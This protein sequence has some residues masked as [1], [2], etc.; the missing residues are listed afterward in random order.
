M[1]WVY[2]GYQPCIYIYIIVKN[3]LIVDVCVSPTTYK[4]RIGN[5]KSLPTSLWFSEVSFWGK[6]PIFRGKLLVSGRVYTL[7]NQDLLHCSNQM[8]SDQCVLPAQK[9]EGWLP[10]KAKKHCQSQS[11]CIPQSNGRTHG[12]RTRGLLSI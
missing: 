5:M 2:P 12:P 3:D 11:S 9:L 1:Y 4:V 7:N 10:Y 8:R 6:R